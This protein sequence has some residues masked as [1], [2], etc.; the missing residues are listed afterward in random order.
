MC[1]IFGVVGD[2]SK[3]NRELLKRLN[4]LGESSKRRGSDSSGFVTV[5]GSKIL[6]TKGSEDIFKHLS[7][8][9]KRNEMSPVSFLGGFTR[10]ST[11]GFS[12]ESEFGQPVFDSGLIVMHNG[13]VTNYKDHIDPEQ[14]DSMAINRMLSGVFSQKQ[15]DDYSLNEISKTLSRLKGEITFICINLYG[16]VIAYTNVGNLYLSSSEDGSIWFASESNSLKKAKLSNIRQLE[17]NVATFIHKESYSEMLPT[18]TKVLSDDL[19]VGK[20]KLESRK[21]EN[22]FDSVKLLKQANLV[23]SRHNLNRCKRCVLPDSFPGIEFNESGIC[24]FCMK[25]KVPPVKNLEDLVVKLNSV[26]GDG[27]HVQVNISGGRDSSYV[28]IR[29][30][31]LGFKIKAVTYDWGFVTTA[32]RENVAN[33]CGA[34]GIEH[35]VVSPNINLNRNIVKSCI[36]GWFKNPNAGTIPALM[37]GDKFQLSSSVQISEEN[38]NM[39]IIQGDHWLETTGFKSALAGAKLDYDQGGS[40]VSYRLPISSVLK[41]SLAYFKL[42]MQVQKMRYLIARQLFSSAF[43]YYVK[44]HKLIHYFEYENW[45]ESVIE[46]KISEYGWKSNQSEVTKTNW[47]MGDAT[48]PFYNLLYL[49]MIGFTENDALRSNQIRVGAISRSDALKLLERDNAL[50][51]EGINSYLKIIDLDL[52]EFWNVLFP[53]FV[54]KLMKG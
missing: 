8:H 29:L 15:F 48:A 2:N 50:D 32:A 23:L 20:T 30:H 33:L 4:G 52:S 38:G 34:L 39:P 14:I 22:D 53:A 9:K 10:L 7:F 31:E 12:D 35:I 19:G 42:I 11:H 44:D 37:A 51:F 45:D 27:G 47:R 5:S 25:W 43:V 49:L 28:L 36:L 13:I 16:Q 24:N 6:I 21:L 54:S 46:A 1:G 17:M 18:E 40:G 3:I 26:T 41:M